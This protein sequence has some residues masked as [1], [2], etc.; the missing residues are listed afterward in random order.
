MINEVHF[1]IASAAFLALL[2]F[3]DLFKRQ[4]PIKKVITFQVLLC[5]MMLCSFS[6]VD[7]ILTMRYS[8]S[9]LLNTTIYTGTMIIGLFCVM[10]THWHVMSLTYRL[11]RKTLRVKIDLCLFGIMILIIALSPWTHWYYTIS[12]QGEYHKTIIAY[13]MIAVL[14]IYLITDLIYL[15][16]GAREYSLRRKLMCS[17]M[18]VCFLT[19]AFRDVSNSQSYI[20]YNVFVVLLTGIVSGAFIML[21]GGHTTPVDL[22]TNMGSG[23]SGMFETC[24]VAILV[25][26]MCALI[27]EYGGFDALLSWIHKIFRGKKGGQIGMGL[28]VGTMDI[29]TANNTVAIVMANPIAKEMAEEYG[30]TPRK[31]ASILDTFSCI[32][33]GVIPY[34]AQMLVAISAVNE[35]GGEISAFQIMPKLFYPMLLLLSSIFAIMRSKK[36]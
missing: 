28:L 14:C 34:G 15:W 3:T 9:V 22:L 20:F 1:E 11:D 25:A 16:Y 21:I 35:L 32:F 31:T 29:A 2:F 23:V 27:R 8:T 13:L 17:C 6:T 24:M 5:V 30:I 33:Q 18:L 19:V 7:Y 4:L 36:V 12:L 26:A 10:A